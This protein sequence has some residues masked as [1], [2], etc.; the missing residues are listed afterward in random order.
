MPRENMLPGIL[1]E[2]HFEKNRGVCPESVSVKQNVWWE[3]KGERVNCTENCDHPHKWWSRIDNRFA[4]DGTRKGGCPFCSRRALCPCQSLANRYPDLA[5]QFHATKNGSLTPQNVSTQSNKTVVWICSSKLNC[6]DSCKNAHEWTSTVQDRVNGRGCPYCSIGGKVFC[7]CRCLS[8]QRPDLAGQWHQTRNGSLTPKDVSIGSARRVFW[9]CGICSHVYNATI[10]HRTNG[11]GCPKCCINK[12]EK[13]LEEI[14]SLHTLV[15]R[16]SKP[17]ISCYDHIRKKQRTLR[18]DCI[19]TT[20][21][22]N[23][24]MIELDGR[25]HF[26]MVYWYDSNGSDLEDQICRDLCKNLYAAQNGMSLLRVS[27]KEYGDLDSWVNKFL[28]KCSKTTGQ[29]MIPSNPAL[30]NNQRNIAL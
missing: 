11:S 5:R 27:Y 21:N 17:G 3:C 25:Q 16:Y 18:P 13:R 14:L 6:T 22:G 23:K 1:A 9:Q 24:F 26:E 4:S 10:R 2:W 12:A 30:Y 28:E 8:V 29:V 20:V 7:P 19:G 15:S